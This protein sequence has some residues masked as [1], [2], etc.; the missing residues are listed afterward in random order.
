M[1]QLRRRKSER[2]AED[3]R[4]AI[5]EVAF[6][7][8]AR[9]GFHGTSTKAIA[10]EAGVS[11]GLIFHHFENKTTILSAIVHRMIGVRLQRILRSMLA[12]RENDNLED[13]LKDVF[14]HIHKSAS[15]GPMRNVVRLIF[16]S[17]LTLPDENKLQFIKQIHDTLWFPF[18]EALAPRLEKSG[19][20]P[21]IYL[22]MV[23]GSVM[24]YVLFQE[25]LEWKKFID[26][27]PVQYRDTMAHI[28]AQA[29]KIDADQAKKVGPVKK[30]KSPKQSPKSKIAKKKADSKMSAGH[31]KEPAMNRKQTPK[32]S[33]SKKAVMQ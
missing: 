22:R 1:V 12:N 18:A 21:Y 15:E 10:A 3:S 7:L 11:E 31:S 30:A 25:V 27:N 5:I 24:G 17:L 23:Q 28:L 29:V 13:I 32:Q 16:N 8:F 14:D 19:I 26:L 6:K 4:S 9:N 2:N 20:D 33:S